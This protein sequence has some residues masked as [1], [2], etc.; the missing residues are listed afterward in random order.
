MRGIQ[1]TVAACPDR[2]AIRTRD[3]EF[4]CT[5]GEYAERVEALATGLA[6]LGVEPGDTVAL[7]LANRPEFHFADSAV[8]H[9]GATPFSIYNTYTVEQIEHL[10]DDAGSRVVITE[11]AYL[12]K[13]LSA[14]EALDSIEQVV[15]VDGDP[16][17][18]SIS[19]TDLA[20]A[21]QEGFDFEAS[22]K[23]VQPDDVLTLI[24]T[25]GTTGPPKGVQITHANIC[26]TVRS[27]DELIVFP[28]GGRIVSY[29]PMAHVAERNVSHYLP[30]LL[31]FTVTCCPDPR[32]VMAYLP[33]V[34]PTW[35][36]AVPGSGRS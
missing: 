28:D 12:D 24:Y 23:A 33:E 22:W 18:D 10:L 21:G 9:L 31:G 14:R 3:D 15:V 16:V 30:M 2:T 25:S 6:S 13:I 32:E 34:R 4:S 29:L 35:F 20:E 19:L 5:W 8:M 7:M 17:A 11:Q 1:A 26:E 27:Y 36:F